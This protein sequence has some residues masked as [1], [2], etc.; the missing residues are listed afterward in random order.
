MRMDHPTYSVRLS[1]F[2]KEVAY[3]LTDRALVWSEGGVER[4]LDFSDIRQ[5]RVYDSPGVWSM[6][7]FSRCVIKPRRGRARIL[8]SNHFAG[9]GT[10]EVRMER[11]RPFVD[12]L[13]R[14]VAAANPATTFIA[15][16]PMALWVSYL[17]ILVGLVIVTPL[18]VV[19]AIWM[20]LQGAGMSGGFVASLVVCLGFLVGIVPMWRLVRRNRPRPFDPRVRGWVLPQS[21]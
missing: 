16:M 20:S 12:A 5:I 11:Y 15:G 21:L 10:F 9:V 13:I 19:L 8:S 18:G 1:L 2:S 7:T 17:V 4:S 3:R 14:Q 6:P